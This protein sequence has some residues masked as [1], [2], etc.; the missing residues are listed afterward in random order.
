MSSLTMSLRTSQH[1]TWKSLSSDEMVTLSPE[2][3]LIKNNN[4]DHW[5]IMFWRV[6]LKTCAYMLMRAYELYSNYAT[7]IGTNCN[8]KHI[9]KWFIDCSNYSYLL[10]TTWHPVFQWDCSSLSIKKRK[11]KLHSQYNT[12][13][14]ITF[15][16]C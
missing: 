13:Y 6:L 3:S 15:Q 11:W 12:W 8:L 16:Y 14:Y 1:V 5:E 2:P 10:I 7:V 4:I 9:R